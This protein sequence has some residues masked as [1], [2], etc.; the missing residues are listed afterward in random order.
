MVMYRNPKVGDLIKIRP[1]MGNELYRL[2]C[3]IKVRGFADVLLDIN[4]VYMVVAVTQDKRQ[5]QITGSG[6]NY[7][8]TDWFYKIASASEKVYKVLFGNTER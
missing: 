8:Y 1:E 2:N 3:L 6:I 5:F 7:Y 4:K